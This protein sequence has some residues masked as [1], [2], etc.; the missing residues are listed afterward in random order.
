MS[1]S[2]E[3][4]YLAILGQRGD[5]DAFNAA[6]GCLIV[7][8][9]RRSVPLLLLVL[10]T[11]CRRGRKQRGVLRMRAGGSVRQTGQR[12]RGRQSGNID[13]LV[14]RCCNAY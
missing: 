8:I 3:F 5:I 14:R 7:I 6:A 11:E 1:S 4:K 2:F 13:E 10:L 12:T 9:Q